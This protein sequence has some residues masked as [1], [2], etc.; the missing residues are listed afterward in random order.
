MSSSLTVGLA[1]VLA[2][3]MTSNTFAVAASPRWSFASLFQPLRRRVQARV[4]RRFNGARYDAERTLTA[5]AGR[6]RDE[7]DLDVVSR[8]VADSIGG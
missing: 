6:L 7:V 5:F 2:H 3:V 4:D 1:A 8:D